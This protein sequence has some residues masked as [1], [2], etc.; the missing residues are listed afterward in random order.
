[1][2][3]AAFALVAMF[4]SFAAAA[5]PDVNVTGQYASSY[6]AVSLVQFG[7]RVTGTYVC[8]GS[9][10]IEGQIQGRI[11]HYRWK[12]PSGWGS[13]VWLIEPGHLDGTWGTNQD[14]KNGG[15]W[16]LVQAKPAQ[17]IAN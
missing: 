16:D 8:C 11:L 1:M 2:R 12:Q 3:L 13:G 7:D 14:E 15:R 5:G 4:T 17:K 6:G 10:T 9:G